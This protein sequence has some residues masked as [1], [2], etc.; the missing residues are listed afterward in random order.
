MHLL[1]QDIMLKAMKS[2]NL[3]DDV[4]VGKR[5]EENPPVYILTMEFQEKSVEAWISRADFS[6][7]VLVSVLKELW[8]QLYA[9]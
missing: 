5:V 6:E 1:T 4:W 7:A 8:E 3:P 9:K 2:I